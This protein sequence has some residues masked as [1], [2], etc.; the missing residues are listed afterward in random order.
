MEEKLE[1]VGYLT[2]LATAGGFGA[3]VWYLVMK[4]IPAIEARHREERLEAAKNCE[5]ERIRNHAALESICDKFDQ[6]CREQRVNFLDRE[7]IIAGEQSATAQAIN[8][9]KEYIN[10]N[11]NQ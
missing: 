11:E 10:V 9:I 5:A 7:R 8:D 3:L 6:H 2:Q 1:W 4:H